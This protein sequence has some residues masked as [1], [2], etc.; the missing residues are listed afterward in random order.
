MV[1][2]YNVI[3][4]LKLT[5]LTKTNLI[6]LPF[7]FFFNENTSAQNIS[8]TIYKEEDIY[9]LLEQIQNDDQL[10]LE[11]LSS[12]HFHKMLNDYRNSKN[13][14]SVHW[15][16]NLWMA[17]RNH[18]IYL[19]RDIKHLSH[20]QIRN[21][22][23]FTGNRP[24]DRVEFV[25]YNSNE[26]KFAGFENCYGI[27]TLGRMPNVKIEI[28]E[29]NDMAK[30]KAEEAF[31]AWRKSSAHNKNMLDAEHITHGT[32]IVF[33]RFGIHGTSIF[34]RKQKYYEPDTLFLPFM[35]NIVNKNDFL[36]DNNYQDFESHKDIIPRVNYKY[37]YLITDFFEKREIDA[38]KT[39]YKI[40]QLEILPKTQK[41][42]NKFYRKERGVKGIFEL[43][44]HEP[45]CFQLSYDMNY[46]DYKKLKG[47][48]VVRDWLQNQLENES[49]D[50]KS[51]GG[52]IKTKRRGKEVRIEM[53]LVLLV[54]KN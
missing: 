5:F 4:F 14:K 7:V 40:T 12:L 8:D 19:L 3:Q 32:S 16:H 6:L 33:G 1:S 29:M 37:F 39:M 38:N 28:K 11:W 13:L 10:Q 18:N 22:P 15:D 48:N 42:L 17:A 54:K 21:K 9:R 44:T 43:M 26:L 51:W 24:E 34:A 20:T 30:D 23:F 46:E 52:N 31:E 45:K 27:S 49:E 25:T 36:I 2:R 35:Q 53:D 41:E 47:G 50:I